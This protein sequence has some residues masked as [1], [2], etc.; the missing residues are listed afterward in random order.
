MASRS[1]PRPAARFE[2]LLERRI[3]ERM[4]AV[5]LTQRCWF[6]G[7]PLHVDERVLIPRSPIAEL[8]EQRFTPWVEPARVRRIARPR[9]GFGLHCARLRAGLSAGA[10]RCGGHRCRT[11]SPWRASTAGR[12]GLTRRVRLLESDYFRR[13]QGAPLRYHREQSALRGR[14]GICAACRRSI[15]HEP[16]GA[17]RSGPDG[18]DAVRVLLREAARHLTPAGRAGRRGGQHRDARAAGVSAAAVHVARVRARRRRCVPADGASS[19]GGGFA[20]H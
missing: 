5:Y 19:C 3:R 20:G 10:R 4:P 14:S 18:M 12:C 13:W 1:V 15:G 11:R 8:I 6:A 17:L 7:L 2:A 9:H 16:A